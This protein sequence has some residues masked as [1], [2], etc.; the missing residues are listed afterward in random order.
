MAYT[1]PRRKHK[2]N[3]YDFAFGM[4]VNWVD[5]DTGKMY[6]IQEYKEAL[7]NPEIPKDK[8]PTKI[9]IISMDGKTDLGEIAPEVL[10]EKMK[11]PKPD[12]KY[13]YDPLVHGKW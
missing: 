7:E 11:D 9:K 12:P 13:E 1:P 2:L 3:N 8:K 6:L 10:A 5:M 4:G